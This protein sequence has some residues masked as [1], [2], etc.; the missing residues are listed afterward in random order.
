MTKFK[1]TKMKKDIPRYTGKYDDADFLNC[2]SDKEI[3][4]YQDEQEEEERER[5]EEQLA[6]LKR[7]IRQEEA[8]AE[9]DK[10]IRRREDID[11][12]IE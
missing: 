1:S 11:E 5:E 7:D 12:E 6:E 8:E 10:E 9:G 4:E 2:P 3:E